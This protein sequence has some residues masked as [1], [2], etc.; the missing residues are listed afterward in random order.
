MR[1]RILIVDDHPLIA[2]GLQLALDARGWE[3]VVADGTNPEAVVDHARRFGADGVLLDLHLGP[4]LGSGVDLIAPLTETGAK[5]VIITAETSRTALAACLEAG[6]VC[7][8]GKDLFLDDVVATLEDVLTGG[9]PV[10][11]TQREVM[12]AELRAERSARSGARAVFTR[13]TDRERCVLRLLMDG[14]SAEEIAEERFVALSTVR[15]QIR[16]VLCKLGVRSQLAA[17]ALAHRAGWHDDQ[18]TADVPRSA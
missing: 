3:A 10:G 1:R 15:S 5:V 8:I 12:I 18:D 14:L 2:I 7:W 11:R 16:S 4:E 17:V 6:A 9:S 13:L